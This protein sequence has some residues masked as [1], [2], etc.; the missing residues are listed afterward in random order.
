MLARNVLA[1]IAT[2][3]GRLTLF[4]RKLSLRT[5]RGSQE[6]TLRSR[7]EFARVLAEDFRLALGD[8]DLDAVM[9][10]VG[11]HDAEPVRA[12]RSG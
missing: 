2:A 4:N 12:P 10:A 6:T 3:A 8:A 1:G 5:E 11:R 9:Q 7:A